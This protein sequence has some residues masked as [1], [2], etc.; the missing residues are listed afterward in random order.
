MKEKGINILSREERLVLL[1]SGPVLSKDTIDTCNEMIRKGID[2]RVFL[3][4]CDTARTSSIVY[5]NLRHNIDLPDDIKER[6]KLRY[7]NSLRHNLILMNEIKRII[8][9]M[10]EGGVMAIPLKGPVASVQVFGDIAVYTGSDIDILVRPSDLNRAKRILIEMGYREETGFHEK[11]FIQIS[12]HLPPY[13]RDGFYVEVHWNLT[14]KYFHSSPDFWWEEL[15][16]IEIEGERFPCLSPEKYILYGIF[17]L[18]SHAFYPL[19]FLVF[20]AGLIELNRERIDWDALISESRGLG[21]GRLLGFTLSMVK[22]FFDIPVPNRFLKGDIITRR[23]MDMVLRGIFVDEPVL[24]RR[25][26]VYSC[27]ND[28]IKGYLSVIFKRLFPGPAEI[29][30]RYGIAPESKRVVLYYLLNPFYLFMGRRR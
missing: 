16:E 9:A 25:M 13:V 17:R 12:Y 3:S 5:R 18:F 21:M 6:L 15:E 2:W 27:L 10:R 30:A 14:M 4:R 26:I 1:I 22:E 28:S 24:T 19:K 23:I 8:S 11:D 20:V 7:L 29:R